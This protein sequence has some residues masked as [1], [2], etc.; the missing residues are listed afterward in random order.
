[1][2]KKFKFNLKQLKSEDFKGHALENHLLS[3][4]RGGNLGFRNRK[5]KDSFV[6]V[7][8]IDFHIT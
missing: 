7:I 6:D 5:L 3:S 1:M 4:I 8:F 2:D